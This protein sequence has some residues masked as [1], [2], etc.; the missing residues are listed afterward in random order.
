[1]ETLNEIKGIYSVCMGVCNPEKWAAAQEDAV[2]DAPKQFWYGCG[3]SVDDV[4]APYIGLADSP[5]FSEERLEIE[6]VFIGGD[7]NKKME[8]PQAWLDAVKSPQ[9]RLIY[10]EENGSRRVLDCADRICGP[11]VPEHPTA[12]PVIAWSRK[13]GNFW[14]LMLCTGTVVRCLKRSEHVMATPSVTEYEGKYFVSVRHEGSTE[15]YLEDGRL[16]YRLDGKFGRLAAGASAMVLVTECIGRSIGTLELRLYNLSDVKKSFS[17]EM[18]QTVAVSHTTV[19][20]HTN[21]KYMADKTGLLTAPPFLTLSADEI[22]LGAWPVVL[23]NNILV[24]FEA[25]PSWG[26]DH[27]LTM[28]NTLQVWTCSLECGE[29]RPLSAFPVERKKVG[30]YEGM[31]IGSGLFA[32]SIHIG[33]VRLYADGGSLCLFAKRFRAD[34]FR[35]DRWDVCVSEY[36]GRRFGDFRQISEEFGAPDTDY[37]VIGKGADVFVGFPVY[38]EVDLSRSFNYKVVVGRLDGREFEPVGPANAKLAFYQVEPSAAGISK[39]PRESFSAGGYHFVLGDLHTHSSYSKCMSGIDG[40]PAELMRWYM[41]ILQLQVVTISEHL[42]RTSHVE[43]TWIYDTIEALAAEEHIV[44]YSNE[45]SVFPD[46][47]TNLYTCR[48][49]WHDLSRLIPIYSVYRPQMFEGIKKYLPKGA[50]LALRHCHGHYGEDDG[51]YSEATLKTYDPELEPAMEALQLRGNIILGESN[52]NPTKKFPCNFLNQGYQ[53]G[54][55]GGT[56]HNLNMLCNRLGMTG[57]WVKEKSPEGIIEAIRNH[58]TVAISNGKAIIW[59]DI[60]GNPMGS[61]RLQCDKTV[62]IHVRVSVPEIIEAIGLIRNGEP[63]PLLPV[64]TA[65]FDGI[66]TD[67]PEI[68]GDYWYCVQVR[69]VSI[70]NKDNGCKAAGVMKMDTPEGTQVR[71]EYSMIFTSPHFVTVR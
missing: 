15:V 45:P 20:G 21:D 44:I 18:C 67:E 2:S 1:M 64:G 46:H 6:R 61:E 35:G 26:M 43:Y 37:S 71:N 29:A 23:G 5:F 22:N 41:D 53:F 24:A 7:R 38:S 36:D 55:V 51:V 13:C 39:N 16:L 60:D 66:L 32:Q 58:R 70:F 47:D 33:N 31:G 42:D 11:A 10:F 25:R 40:C 62:A 8:I 52:E 9:R 19:Q 57:F 30:F 14:E 4:D 50:V 68:P 34:G 27:C 48:R 69:S 49:E 63:L 28:T 17:L 65:C 3:W 59:T 12:I 54:L 56:D